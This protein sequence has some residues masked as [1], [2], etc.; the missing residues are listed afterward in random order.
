MRFQADERGPLRQSG[1]HRLPGLDQQDSNTPPDGSDTQVFRAL[2]RGLKPDEMIEMATRVTEPL[3]APGQSPR[4]PPGRS[5]SLY[6]AQRRQIAAVAV[7]FLVLL[8]IAGQVLESRTE[9]LAFGLSLAQGP[10]LKAT[11]AQTDT[12]AIPI[13][14]VP[15]PPEPTTAPVGPYDN[16]TPPPGYTSFA[17]EDFSTDPWAYS[18]GQC[19]WWVRYKR[20]DE[21]LTLMG[22]AWNWANAAR[23]RGLTVTTTPAANATVVFAPYVQGAGGLGHVAHVEQLL[24]DGWVLVSEMN[25]FWNGGGLGRVSYR[26]IQAGDGVW[27]IN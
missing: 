10:H 3:P 14:N 5:P 11:G 15:Q 18:F 9:E 21:N 22:D 4:K 12:A 25:F 16:W 13:A 17:I 24:S 26:Y 1:L 2:L 19:T 8:G 27:F 20:L 6:E 7:L 23:A